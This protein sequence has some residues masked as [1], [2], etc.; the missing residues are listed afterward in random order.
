MKQKKGR[1]GERG[2]DARTVKGWHPRAAGVGGCQP[3]HC[4]VIKM[5]ALLTGIAGCVQ[6]AEHG[7]AWHPTSLGHVS[8]KSRPQDDPPVWAQLEPRGSWG[9]AGKPPHFTGAQRGRG[10]KRCAHG[11]QAGEAGQA[12]FLGHLTQG[13]GLPLVPS[14]ASRMGWGAGHGHFTGSRSQRLPWSWQCPIAHLP[15]SG[16]HVSNPTPGQAKRA[17]PSCLTLWGQ[18]W[19]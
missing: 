1:R 15:A 6:M 13:P 9:R 7:P 12:L 17:P 3:A 10:G 18:L 11:H 2:E 16:S 4:S 8:P 5:P 14:L 19:S